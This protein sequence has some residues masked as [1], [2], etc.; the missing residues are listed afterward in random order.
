[1]TSLKLLFII[2]LFSLNSVNAKNLK[3]DECALP[4]DVIDEI[5]G[6]SDAVDR[7]IDLFLRGPLKGETWKR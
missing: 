6:Y 4:Q 7:I 2:F 3:E 1:M 5:A